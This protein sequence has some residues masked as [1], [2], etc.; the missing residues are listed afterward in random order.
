M[1]GWWSRPQCS[2]I[3]PHAQA[4]TVGASHPWAYCVSLRMRWYAGALSNACDQG[5]SGHMAS[6]GQCLQKQRQHLWAC[7]G[8]GCCCRCPAPPVLLWHSISA[9]A[10]RYSGVPAAAAILTV[11]SRGL[12]GG[13]VGCVFRQ[14]AALGHRPNSW[15]HVHASS[16]GHAGPSA[17]LLCRTCPHAQLKGLLVACLV[18]P[19]RKDCS[20]RGGL[21]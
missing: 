11:G 19:P 18:S 10:R 2:S 12:V 6:Q 1:P 14:H 8:P 7:P 5:C 4:S 20:G 17:A 15:I 21:G 16:C 9:I 13:S 3:A